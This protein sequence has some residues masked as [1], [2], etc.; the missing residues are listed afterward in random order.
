MLHDYYD[1]FAQGT[2]ALYLCYN[3]LL[4]YKADGRPD[5]KVKVLYFRL[6]IHMSENNKIKLLYSELE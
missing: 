5:S 6:S 4:L 1:R 3:P 2:A